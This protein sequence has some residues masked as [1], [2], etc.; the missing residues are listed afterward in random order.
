[1]ATMRVQDS[2]GYEIK[3]LADWAKLYNTL[4]T[5]HQ[6]KVG[7]S[8]YSAAEF[9]INRDGGKVIQ[10]WVEEAICKNIVIE[11]VIP[12][13]EVRFDKFG[14]GRICMTLLYLDQPIKARLY[15]LVL[16]QRL[17]RLLVP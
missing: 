6:W 7:R 8:A 12:E 16:K 17:M 4:Q 15:L 14:R 9:I 5:S 11:R 2:R 10:K 13:Y 3:S 1:M